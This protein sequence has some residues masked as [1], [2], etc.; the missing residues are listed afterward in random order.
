VVS[1]KESTLEMLK[2]S[3]LFGSHGKKFLIFSKFWLNV[4]YYEYSEKDLG[5]DISE[6]TNYNPFKYYEG[7]ELSS[8]LNKMVACC[9]Y[10]TQIKENGRHGDI[11]PRSILWDGVSIHFLKFQFSNFWSVPPLQAD[12]KR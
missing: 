2:L 12:G 10:L 6:R 5:H 3:L 11:R 9:D 1:M 7:R 4:S 8:I